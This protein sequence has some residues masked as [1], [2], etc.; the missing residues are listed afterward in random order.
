MPEYKFKCK[1]CKKVSILRYTLGEVSVIKHNAIMGPCKCG[2]YLMWED[3]QIE[4]QGAINMNNS[5]KAK[6]YR[7]YNNKVGG[8]K[9]IIGGKVQ[10]NS[11]F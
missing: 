8:P 1:V 10:P 7:R 3:I 2:E 11:G 4:F 6:A 9:S 5:I